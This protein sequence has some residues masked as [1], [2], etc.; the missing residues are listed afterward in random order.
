MSILLSLLACAT[1]SSR[2]TATA[3]EPQ[4]QQAATQQA[5]TQQAATQQVGA[6]AAGVAVATDL[7]VGA[8]RDYDRV[9]IEF[10]GGLPGYELSFVDSIEQAGSGRP[11]ELAGA[12][13]FLITLE[14]A[15]G[16]GED[17]A[18]TVP[19]SADGSGLEA[20][21]E[22]RLIDDYEGQLRFAVGLNTQVEPKVQTLSNPPRL[23]LDFPR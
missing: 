10:R 4:E 11:V 21:A 14:P 2:T 6:P 9:V 1:P 7:R 22:V 19:A 20:V 23:V 13:S 15:S 5:A 18:S 12:A 3:A 17:G 8:H 16:H